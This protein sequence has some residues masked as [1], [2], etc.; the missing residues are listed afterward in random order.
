MCI[1]RV[2]MVV[3]IVGGNL[4]FCLATCPYICDTFNSAVVVPATRPAELHVLTSRWDS[5]SVLR[6][7]TESFS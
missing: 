1:M 3:I 5:S 4:F 6:R 2:V 7:L